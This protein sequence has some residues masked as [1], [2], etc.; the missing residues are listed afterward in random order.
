MFQETM[1]FYIVCKW[2]VDVENMMEYYQPKQMHIKPDKLTR[3]RYHAVI[4]QGMCG[5]IIRQWIDETNPRH[6]D[7]CRQSK[8]HNCGDV[9]VLLLRSHT[10]IRRVW[11]L[12]LCQ[13]ITQHR[14][15]RRF[16][17]MRNVKLHDSKIVCWKPE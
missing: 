5:G 3:F 9:I 14:Y 17:E 10:K 11:K 2:R 15:D 4:W 13:W 16:C 7:Y 8:L 1:E 12:N 6:S